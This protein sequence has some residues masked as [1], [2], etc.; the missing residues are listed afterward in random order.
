MYSTIEWKTVIYI[1]TRTIDESVNKDETY[2]LSSQPHV[3]IY[4][5]IHAH[6][7]TRLLP[8]W[9]RRFRVVVTGGGKSAAG[10]G[11]GRGIFFSRFLTYQYTRT[12]RDVHGT[13]V[14]NSNCRGTYCVWRAHSR[15]IMRLHHTSSRA[16]R[17]L[18]KT[19]TL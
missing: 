5:Y 8:K 3:P 16:R 13:Y 18:A 15:T 1:Y 6:T 19:K 11:P 7:C 4:I 12:G 10:R 17:V 2:L 9:A 14:R